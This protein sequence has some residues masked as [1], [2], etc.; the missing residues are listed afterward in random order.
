MTIN[1]QEVRI[2]KEVVMVFSKVLSQHLLGKTEEN[3]ET[4]QRV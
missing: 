1:G 2:W 4:P 3:L